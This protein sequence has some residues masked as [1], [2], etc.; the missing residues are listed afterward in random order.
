MEKTN[1]KERKVKKKVYNKVQKILAVFF[2][3]A[4]LV[5]SIQLPPA[6]AADKEERETNLVDIAADCDITVASEQYPKENMVDKDQETLW[7]QNG[8]QWPSEVSFR[9]PMDNTKKIKKVVIE[10][11]KNHP[12]WSV[13]VQLSH[14]LNNVTSDLIVDDV[15]ENHPLTETYEYVYDTALNYTHTY[16]TLSNPQDNG[17]V[18]GFCPAIAEVQIWAEEETEITNVASTANITSVGGDA[19]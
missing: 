8:G 1:E 12:N 14:A 13:D 9:L 2:V 3:L 7:I 6:A 4:L 18:G 17:N 15:T 10:F 19:E 5:T 11:E 16:I